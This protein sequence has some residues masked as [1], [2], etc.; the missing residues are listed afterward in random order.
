MRNV[1]PKNSC[2]AAI[3]PIYFFHVELYPKERAPL[4]LLYVLYACVFWRGEA[5]LLE[6]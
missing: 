4:H 2:R 1:L 6:F 3:F 5:D